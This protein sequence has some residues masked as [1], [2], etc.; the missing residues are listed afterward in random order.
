LFDRCDQC[1]SYIRDSQQRGAS[2][3]QTYML[4][5]LANRMERMS[6]L[7]DLVDKDHQVRRWQVRRVVPH[8]GP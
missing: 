3:H 4:L 5:L 7:V 2:L 8:A 1:I 6:I